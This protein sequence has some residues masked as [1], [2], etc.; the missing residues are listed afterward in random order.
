MNSEPRTSLEGVRV[1]CVT[2]MEA[3]AARCYYRLVA[4]IP[5]SSIPSTRGVLA[6]I[7]NVMRRIIGAPD[8]ERY[9]L[10]C[11]QAHPDMEPLTEQE[12]IADHMNRKVK[13][14]SRCC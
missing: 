8:Y 14:G 3:G 10:H 5:A 13:P 4:T 2:N 11:R 12:F 9:L 6:Q 7:A 1:I